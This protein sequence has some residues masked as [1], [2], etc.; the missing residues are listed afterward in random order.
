MIDNKLWQAYTQVAFRFLSR[1][2][3]QEFAV[4]TAWNPQSLRL[5]DNENRKNNQRL[6]HDLIGYD[7]VDVLVGD[8]G[9]SWYEESFAV[10]L[11]LAE[12]K[13]LAVKYAQNAI[14]Y[15]VNDEL[16]L[17]SCVSRQ[18]LCLGSLSEKRT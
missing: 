13:K 17:H 12:A 15:V 7:W 4:I 11:P 14:Y 9:F 3:K 8:N 10:C 1:P 2:V 6:Q 5:S 18:I 16:T